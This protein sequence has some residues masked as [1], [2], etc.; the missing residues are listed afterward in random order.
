MPKL[1][2]PTVRLPLFSLG[3]SKWTRKPVGRAINVRS[4]GCFSVIS[5]DRWR[6]NPIQYSSRGTPSKI[7]IIVPKVPSKS[8]DGNIKSIIQ[9]KA[10]TTN[11]EI[12]KPATKVSRFIL[13]VKLNINKKYHLCGI[14][15]NASAWLRSLPAGR[16]G[17]T[18]HDCGRARNKFLRVAAL[19][20]NRVL[21]TNPVRV[22][23]LRCLW[24]NTGHKTDAF[25]L[26]LRSGGS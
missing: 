16:Q 25:S 10:T 21:R 18:A 19:A 8:L 23:H 17:R 15:H 20:S 3:Q 6:I 24:K 1:C 5:L 7:A 2:F 12:I 14:L 11:N 9:D 13:L 26:A 22:W 4:K